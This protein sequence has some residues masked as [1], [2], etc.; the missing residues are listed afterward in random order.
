[1]GKRII[2]SRSLQLASGTKLTR[3]LGEFTPPVF[4]PI[5][6]DVEG[7]FVKGKDIVGFEAGEFSIPIKGVS[8]A[9]TMGSVALGEEG[10]VIYKEKFKEG[11]TTGEMVHTMTAECYIDRTGQQTGKKS[12]VTLKG[13]INKYAFVD[14]GVPVTTVDIDNGVYFIEGREFLA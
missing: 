10:V 8:S 1:M 12:E 5:F 3:D 11:S 14:G 4:N 2:I 6:E 13:T 7:T 9:I